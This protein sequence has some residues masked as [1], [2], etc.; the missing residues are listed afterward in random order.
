[1]KS[2]S[3]TSFS[4][5]SLEVTSFC[6]YCVFVMLVV[7]CQFS[8]TRTNTVLSMM[9]YKQMRQQGWGVEYFSG[10]SWFQS[11]MR[12]SWMV[13]TIMQSLDSAAI[14]IYTYIY[15]YMY[16]YTYI[17]IY[18]YTCIYIYIYIYIYM[19]HMYR[20]RE[21]HSIISCYYV[22]LCYVTLYDIIRDYMCIY[23]YISLSLYIY[24]YIYA[25]V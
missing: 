14:Y 15:I 21:I 20:A 18:M 9:F 13:R 22:M 25:H 19:I 23:T 11:L 7:L 8:N 17:Y 16:T 3:R 2:P 12:P 24:I 4:G 10:M 1:M 6:V 5:M